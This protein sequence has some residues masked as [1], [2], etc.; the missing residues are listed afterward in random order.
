[1]WQ[2]AKETADFKWIKSADAPIFFQ[3]ISLDDAK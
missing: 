2:L 1:M 3:K